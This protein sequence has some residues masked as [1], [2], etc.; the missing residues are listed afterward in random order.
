MQEYA[1]FRK[2]AF[3]TELLPEANQMKAY[4]KAVFTEFQNA[5]T[6]F[7]TQFKNKMAPQEFRAWKADASYG[8]ISD[9]F[10]HYWEN[11]VKPLDAASF[12]KRVEELGLPK[13]QVT[14][15]THEGLVVETKTGN[16]YIH[17]FAKKGGNEARYIIQQAANKK[18]KRIGFA[19][20]ANT[21]AIKLEMKK[22]ELPKA[23]GPLVADEPAVQP[24]LRRLTRRQGGGCVRNKA[25]FKP[26]FEDHDSDIAEV[27]ASEAELAVAKFQQTA[28][29]RA[30]NVAAKT[31]K[32]GKPFIET[33][34]KVVAAGAV[35]G[36]SFYVI[37]C[38]A[39]NVFCNYRYDQCC[40]YGT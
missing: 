35:V 37:Y 27:T 9:S 33:G 5:E 40:H 8:E 11:R 7:V 13:E 10:M 14:F 38:S 20:D 22:Y 12:A 4:Q 2:G 6:R 21:G 36:F 29:G 31:W 26:N 25:K 18:F 28:S 30:L 16:T 39:L 23:A 32:L 15:A 19:K 3:L 24:C 1:K 17:F 34:A